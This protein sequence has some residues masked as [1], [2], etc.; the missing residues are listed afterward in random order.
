MAYRGDCWQHLRNIIIN[1]MAKA[2]DSL[3]KEKLEGDLAEFSSFERMEV[4][5]SSLIRSCFNQFHHGGEYCKG[6]G[7]EFE[8]YRKKQSKDSLFIPFERAVGSR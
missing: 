5:G 3:V 7:R 8:A 2:A 4:D 1:A 6:R